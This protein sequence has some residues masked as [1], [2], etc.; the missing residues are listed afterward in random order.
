MKIVKIGLLS[1]STL[2]ILVG[3]IWMGFG[4]AVAVMSHLNLAKQLAK[5]VQ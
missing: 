4:F 2:A 3:L 1:A 5:L